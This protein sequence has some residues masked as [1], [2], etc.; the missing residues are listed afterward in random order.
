L[1]AKLI[2]PFRCTSPQCGFDAGR[3]LGVQLVAIGT[4]DFIDGKFAVNIL[5]LHVAS[6]TVVKSVHETFVGDKQ[7]LSEGMRVVANKLLGIPKAE[8]VPEKKPSERSFDLVPDENVDSSNAVKDSDFK[9][10]YVGLGLLVA[11]GIGAGVLLLQNG[12]GSSVTTP[13]D[14]PGPPSFP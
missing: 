2:D 12:S 10:Q 4:I 11:G 13:S 7:V 5:L 14:L 3:A 8:S 1:Y 9:W 6:K